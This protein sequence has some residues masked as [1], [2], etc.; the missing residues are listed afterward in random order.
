MVK[1][2]AANQDVQQIDK[3]IQELIEQRAKIELEK[4]IPLRKQYIEVLAE[5]GRVVAPHGLTASKYLGMSPEQADKFI[6][7]QAYQAHLGAPPVTRRTMKVPP[8]YRHPRDKELTWTGR[9]NQPI[10]VR[11]Y[12]EK[13]GSLDKLLINPAA[14]KKKAAKKRAATK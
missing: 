4:L 10:W 13:G 8:K 9:G 12:L 11:D 3:Q 5:I 6:L 7:E 14:A 1:Q 2:P